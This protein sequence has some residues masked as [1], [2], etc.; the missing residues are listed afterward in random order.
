MIET[1]YENVQGMLCD[2]CVMVFLY[3][4]GGIHFARVKNA[5]FFSTFLKPTSSALNDTVEYMA[6]NCFISQ[7]VHSVPPSSVE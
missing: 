1:D 2:A 3:S 4:Y 7:E 6:A 5:V